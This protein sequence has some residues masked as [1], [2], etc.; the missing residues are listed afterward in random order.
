MAM[1][2]GAP[3]T[4]PQ[5]TDRAFTTSL[6]RGIRLP[7]IGVI[8]LVPV[9]LVILALLPD[10][11]QLV[12][13]T[14]APELFTAYTSHFVHSN[15]AHLVG[16][17]LIYVV[18]VPL[19]YVL[20]VLAGKRQF[21][22][23]SFGALL[24]LFPVALS[25]MQLSFPDERL[26]LGF[27]G[28]NAGFFA[29]LSLSLVCYGRAVFSERIEIRYAP[30]LL[31]VLAGVIALVALPERAWR[32]E[33]AFGTFAL[34]LAYVGAFFYRHGVPERAAVKR[35]LD[36]PGYV[37]LAGI[38]FGAVVAYPVI[39]FQEIVF[40]GDAVTDVY[41]HLLGYCFAFIVLFLYVIVEEEL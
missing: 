20:A 32:V 2:M 25:L 7:D 29:L 33:I 30:A 12:F 24:V 37:E 40:F 28:I 11:T 17:L 15:L 13:N 5:A 38:S 21:F 1:D 22:L 19:A 4:Q 3:T 23:L 41:V 6:I 36:Q 26:V 8:G 27:S 34:A 16:N 31:F 10:S 14:G 39:G 9:V 35:A 18:V